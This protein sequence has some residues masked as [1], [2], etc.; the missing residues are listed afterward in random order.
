MFAE[1]NARRMHEQWLRRTARVRSK[2]QTQC[3]D[4]VDE[5]FFSTISAHIKMKNE[6]SGQRNE[7]NFEISPICRWTTD[8]EENNKISRGIILHA[9]ILSVAKIF[10]KSNV[11]R[12]SSTAPLIWNPVGA[13]ISDGF[14]I[15]IWA[16]MEHFRAMNFEE[17]CAAHRSTYSQWKKS[18]QTIPH[19]HCRC[20]CCRRHKEI[21]I[22]KQQPTDK[23]NDDAAR[24]KQWFKYKL[25]RMAK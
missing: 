4:A 19:C 9:R 8:S 3:S 22:M 1:L 17:V 2:I 13:S 7:E 14:R 5:I 6:H 25:S 20:S 10:P 24:R 18:R 21:Q 12:K 16:A 11:S 23:N 15:A